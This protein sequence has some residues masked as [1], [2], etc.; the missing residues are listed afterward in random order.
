MRSPTVYCG[1]MWGGKTEAL[2]SRLVRARIQEI[3]VLA[4]NP[5]LNDRYG[6]RDIRA[7]SGASFPA[8][9]VHSGEDI[10]EVVRREQP[11]VVGI[12]EFFMI[13][14][15][16]AAVEY[17]VHRRIKVVVS[18]LDLDSEGVIWEGLGQLLA[19]AEEVVKCPAVCAVCKA[20]AYF[21]FRKGYAP[22]ERVLVGADEFYEP[23][24]R[25][26]FDQGQEAKRAATGEGSLFD[27]G[28]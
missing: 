8:N 3:P 6:T 14:S 4:F 13:P 10:L 21:T 20:D 11:Q 19:M 27:G 16:L 26:C 2:I 25:R 12:D 1:P 24:C 5:H 18:T 15:A 28:S 9:P 7:H 17:M 23:R 22:S